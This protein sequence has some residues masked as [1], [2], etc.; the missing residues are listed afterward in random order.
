MA[1]MGRLFDERR[2]VAG[3]TAWNAANAYTEWLQ[4]E[5]KL[6]T[7]D[8]HKAAEQRLQE[9]LFGTSVQRSQKA[10]MMAATI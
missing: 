7:K 1:S 10:M 5:R 3:A 8:P 2:E 4:H 6:Q 9:N